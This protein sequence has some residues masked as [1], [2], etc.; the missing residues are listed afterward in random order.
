MH[1]SHQDAVLAL[2]PYHRAGL[3]SSDEASRTQSV[4]H[5][6]MSTYLTV[7]HGTRAPICSVLRIRRRVLLSPLARAEKASR[8]P[9]FPMHVRSV[10]SNWGFQARGRARVFA[11]AWRCG[12]GRL[13]REDGLVGSCYAR[14]TLLC[15]GSDL[16]HWILQLILTSNSLHNDDPRRGISRHCLVRRLY[17]DINRLTSSCAAA[18][19]VDVS[20]RVD[21]RTWTTISRSY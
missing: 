4:I 16:G 17:I 13:N 14:L 7:V 6:P 8:G 12:V 2:H 21:W 18:G 20:W 1:I 15:C 3:L 9:S 11:G 19:R 10:S 5:A